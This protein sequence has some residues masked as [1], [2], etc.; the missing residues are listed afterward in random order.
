MPETLIVL[1]RRIPRA[2]MDVLEATGAAIQIVEPDSEQVVEPAAVIAAAAA[3]DVLVC[4]LTE[5]INGDVLE[6]G[7]RLRGIA[8]M[9]V[10]FNNIDVTAATAMG[11]PVSNTPGV[12]TDTTADLTWALLL[13][14]AR[15]VVEADAY[16]REGRYRLWGPELMLGADVSPGGSGIRKT[17]GIIG[18]GRIGRA[19]A[20][21][22]SGFDMD[23]LA[24]SPG[25]TGGAADGAAYVPLDELLVRSD[26]IC[27]HA[28]ST[29]ATR[30]M[31]GERELALMKPTACIV[32]V[33]RGDII[34]EKALVRALRG[35]SIGGAALDVFEM[36]PAMA[37]GLA[38]CANTILVPHIGSASHDT[39]NRMAA[40]AAHNAVAHLERRRAPDVVNP[41][42]YDTAAYARRMRHDSE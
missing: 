22:A 26:F 27:I 8:T 37:Q 6:A 35:G 9:A 33:A 24:Y 4:L 13:G 40:M 29:P 28:P 2:G 30:Y 38:D 18:Y 42:V 34:D 23:V 14:I 1:T 17:L 39:R 15:R 41:E 16:M 21:R 36:E 7:S 32:N 3:A 25:R 12:L 20:R 31:I 10:G 19:V 5:A 11:V